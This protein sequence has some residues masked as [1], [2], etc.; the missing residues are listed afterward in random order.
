MNSLILT[1]FCSA[2]AA[3]GFLTG[4]LIAV[5]RKKTAENTA[6]YNGY[7]KGF[8]VGADHQKRIYADRARDA[9]R[10][11]T[12]GRFRVHANREAAK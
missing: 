3:L 9:A 5:K 10:R 8:Q 11:D 6:Y 4:Y 12:K 7:R 1:G 2:V